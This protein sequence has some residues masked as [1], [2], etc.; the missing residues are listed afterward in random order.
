[1]YKKLIAIDVIIHTREWPCNAPK[2]VFEDN[3]ENGMSTGNPNELCQNQR[4]QT[5]H[6]EAPQYLAVN[7]T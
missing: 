3:A 1:M 5:I 7:S 4:S 2:E 6:I